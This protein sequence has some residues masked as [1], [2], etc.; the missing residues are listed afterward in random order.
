MIKL[1]CGKCKKEFNRRQ[2]GNKYCSRSCYWV[3]KKGKKH[4]HGWKISNALSGKPKTKKHVDNV[5]NS[6]RG[7]PRKDIE[8]NKHFMWKGNLV[9]YR[10]LHDW[11][12]RNKEKKNFCEECGCKNRKII[13]KNGV[14]ISYLHL[15]NISG[16]YNREVTDWRYLC[17]KC[18]SKHDKGRGSI[19]KIFSKRSK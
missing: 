6:L 10:A 13:Q 18:H 15:S 5:A 4:K 9:G 17:P 19:K 3:S 12:K 11:I 1:V 2:R 16:K 14:V 7:K 8:N